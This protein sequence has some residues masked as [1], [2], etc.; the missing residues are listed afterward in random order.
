MNELLGLVFDRFVAEMLHVSGA[1]LKWLL[2]VKH[3]GFT[4][5]VLSHDIKY[6]QICGK[7][8]RCGG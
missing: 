4:G 7:I 2:W 1:I 8:K 6:Y 5:I 3:L